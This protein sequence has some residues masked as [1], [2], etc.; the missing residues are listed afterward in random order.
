MVQVAVAEGVNACTQKFEPYYGI[1]AAP[2]GDPRAAAVTAAADMV[3]FFV[4]TA[5]ATIDAEAASSLAAIPDGAAKDAG[6]AAGHAASAATIADR[7]TDGSAAPAFFVP[8]NTDPGMWQVT[9]S[10]PRP[11][12]FGGA[13]VGAFK[14][15]GNVRPFAL[16]SGSQFRLPPP[17]A[18][19]SPEYAHD[20]NE[21]QAVGSSTS[22]VRP[23][24]RSDIAR[25]Y[26]AQNAHQ[27]WNSIARQLSAEKPQDISQ[28][29]RIFAL[30]NIAINDAFIAIF[31]TKY[32]YNLWRPET[33]IPRADE[34]DNSLTVAGPFTPWIV[35]P[36]FPSY[37]SAHGVGAGAA[38]QVLTRFFGNGGHHLTNSAAGVTVTYDSLDAM[39]HDI[40]DARVF[41]GIHYRFEQMAGEAQGRDVANYTVNTVF[42]RVDD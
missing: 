39:V 19:D 11:A 13:Q 21:V 29:A 24:D 42:P 40:A 38:S 18:L 32:Y 28:S 10:C 20:F 27:G 34:D 26:A 6:I 36:C 16:A 41:G 37:A 12:P 23:Q 4:P 33:A 9:P 31:D 8:P 5:A 1:P 2:G 25:V 17:P 15:W 14:H 30:T 3:K 35:T 7:A 22:T